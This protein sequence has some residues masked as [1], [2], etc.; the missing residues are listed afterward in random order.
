LTQQ[1]KRSYSPLRPTFL[2]LAKLIVGARGTVSYFELHKLAYM[3]EY[4]DV[5]K[6]EERLT[7]DYYIRQ[8]MV[9]TVLTFSSAGF[10]KPILPCG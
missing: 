10:R 6:T 9:G 5:R 4:L 8:R 3:A 2:Q 7:S 1:E